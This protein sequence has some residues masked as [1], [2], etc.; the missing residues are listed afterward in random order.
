MIHGFNC[1]RN[2]VRVVVLSSGGKDST[3]ATWWA[4]MQGWDVECLV[5]VHITGNDSMMFQMTNT[6][7]VSLQASSMGVRWLPV[8]SN[9]LEDIEIDD[10]KKALKGEKNSLEAFNSIKNEINSIKYPDDLEIFSGPINV[11]AIVVGA[12]RSDYQKTRIER[13][14]EELGIISYCPLWHNSA[15]EHMNS[16]VT[17]GFDVRI[18]SISTDGMENYW[19]GRKLDQKSLDELISLSKKFRFNLD[20]EGGE[21]ETIVVAA[22][23]FRKEILV[24]GESEWDRVRGV[25]NITSA[26]LE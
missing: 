7:M 10:L 26:S 21:F 6:A 25:W 18:V 3:Y 8:L 1:T 11:D 16:L 13:M 23:H 22:P 4:I 17:N 14:C 19:L 24:F 2:Y 15:E 20:G 5:T 9:G 12:L